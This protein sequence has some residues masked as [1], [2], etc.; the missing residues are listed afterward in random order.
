MAFAVLLPHPI[1]AVTPRSQSVLCLFDVFISLWDM[2]HTLFEDQ[3]N[4]GNSACESS[5]EVH[6]AH[7]LCKVSQK[8]CIKE[9]CLILFNPVVPQ[10]AVPPLSHPHPSA[11]NTHTVRLT[12][13]WAHMWAQCEPNLPHTDG[14][15]SM[16][17]LTLILASLQPLILSFFF[18]YLIVLLE[19]NI[20]IIY[21]F[22]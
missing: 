6:S 7:G 4:L 1:W 10:L 13:V 8:S 11:P 5:L 14:K 16:F 22:A 3:R 9:A 12:Y 2:F 20:H 19:Y 21:F 15:D 18:F 17:P